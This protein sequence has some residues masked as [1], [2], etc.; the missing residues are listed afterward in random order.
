MKSVYFLKYNNYANR[1]LKIGTQMADYLGANSENLLQKIENTSLWNPKD[2]II[3]EMPT[4]VPKTE[5]LDDFAVTEPDYVIVADEYDNIDSRWFV[6]ECR[7]LQ[8]GQ[9]NC[10]LKRDV[11][12]E[13]WQ[14]LVNADCHIDRAI[15]LNS[16]PLIFNPEPITVNQIL[17]SEYKIKDATGVPWIVFYAADK[18]SVITN[19][20]PIKNTYDIETDNL[21][22]W[23]AAREINF[24]PNN[25]KSVQIRFYWTDLIPPETTGVLDLLPN[26]M[27]DNSP[28]S[29]TPYA[30]NALPIITSPSG[31]NINGA[32]SAF[33]S[34]FTLGAAEDAAEI[35]NLDG[36]VLFDNVNE[37]YYRISA[38]ASAISPVQVSTGVANS[39]TVTWA[40]SM[41]SSCTNVTGT[42]AA[43]CFVTKYVYQSISISLTEIAIESAVDIKVPAQ[44]VK[45][46]DAPYYMWCMPYG[47]IEMQVKDGTTKT[48]T[49]DPA[50]NLSIAS[51][52]A[53]KNS[54]DNT[55]DVQIL[56]YC[57]L[58]DEFIDPDDGSIVVDDTTITDFGTITQHTD[59]SVVKGFIFA[60]PKCSFTRFIEAEFYPY[61]PSYKMSDICNK[62]RLYAPNYSSSFEF[63]PARNNGIQGFNIRC[64]Y[65]PIQPYIR[66]APLWSGLY[67]NQMF[68]KDPRGL[69]CS[70][71]YSI[72]R[73][74]DP[75]VQYQ[76][77]NKN[78]EAIFNREIEHMDV[79]RK[80]ER[81]G[82][83]AGALAGTVT[84]AAAGAAAG[85][86]IGGPMGAAVGAVVGGVGSAVSGAADVAHAEKLFQ[87][88]KSY[89]TDLHY[90]QLG[91]VQ[92][93]PRSLSKTTAFNVDNR[94]FPIL[95]YYLPTEKEADLVDQ[96]IN[97]HSMNVDAEGKPIDYIYNRYKREG[98][99]YT[100]R[101]F[102]SGSIIRIEVPFDTHFIDELNKEFQKGVYLR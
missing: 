28:A 27:V 78:F 94:Y 52:I 46:S 85:T 35:L 96:Y 16:D 95:A 99:T 21:V 87:E 37:K 33:K 12:A 55:F 7:R 20:S 30:V 51:E 72:A 53:N 84:G 79:Q 22:T 17:H 74:N 4:A 25:L 48:V 8:R 70:G 9:Y 77:Q 75:W 2:G 90:L 92:A 101:G 15:L 42:I 81:A 82:Q 36:K 50:L 19:Y 24:L 23:E 34:Q 47:K 5:N 68:D 56:P 1:I 29:V 57:P 66:V 32:I 88:S 10:T 13:A 71:N 59:S 83:I 100:D 67:G 80:Y 86:M 93:M 40:R 61:Y 6:I 69:I 38:T 89:A 97:I 49:A 102:I 45:A 39:D 11:F 60:C 44:S 31:I 91:N 26:G 63:S 73:L 64:T 76:E 3:T 65:M 14:D 58:P 54:S 43:T 62:V 18:P 98:D 41:M